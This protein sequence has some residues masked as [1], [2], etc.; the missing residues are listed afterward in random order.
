MFLYLPTFVRGSHP[1][2]PD[3]WTATGEPFQ[4]A[5]SLRAASEA[6]VAADGQTGRVLV[7]DAARLDVLGEPPA[8]AFVPRAAVVNQD[9]DGDLWPPLEIE[10][11]GGLVVRRGA[12]G[13]EVLAIFRR[14]VWDLPKGKLDPGETP[15]QA[16]LREV[17]E[18]VGIPLRSLDAPA[19]AGLTMHGYLWPRREVYVVKTTH[20]YWMTTTADAFEPEEREGIEAVAWT[21]WAEAVERMGF[22]SL[23]AFLSG[24]DPDTIG[25]R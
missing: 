4:L 3:G 14:G 2:P 16:A 17:S 23:R 12:S 22:E 24:L 20:W 25:G 11:A 7:L 18:E 9:P 21:P 10:A 19:L 13:V 15:H 1:V 5:T 8:A 6:A